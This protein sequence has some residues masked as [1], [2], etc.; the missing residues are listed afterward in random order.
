[1]TVMAESSPFFGRV[2]EVGI[3]MEA[4][5]RAS[6]GQSQTLLI[7]GEAGIGKT[8][9]LEELTTRISTETCAQLRIGAAV[10]L[11]GPTFPYGPFTAALRDLADWLP[12]DDESAHH[13]TRDCLTARCHLF[14]RVLA[15]LADLAAHT[16]FVLV[17]EDLQWAD[18]STRDLL[19]F[20]AVRLRAEHV[21]LAATIREEDLTH[22]ALRWL[23]EL[24]RRPRVTRLRL[25]RLADGDIG[26]LVTGLLPEPHHRHEAEA[27]VRAA[28][29]NPLYARELAR[30]EAHRSPASIAETVLARVSG[31]DPAVQAVVHQLSVADEGMSHDLLAATVPLPEPDLLAATRRSVS[32]RLFV[33]TG[34]VYTFAHTLTGRILYDHL[35]PG[36]RRLLHRRLADALAERG[37]ADPAVLSH[38]WYRAGRHDRAATAA[39]VAARAAMAAHAYPEA[40]S[41]YALVVELAAWLP[42]WGPGILGDAARAASL[43]GDPRRATT[44]AAQALALSATDAVTDRA[45]QLE[46]LARYHWEC[47]DL[48]ASVEAADRAADLLDG[49]PPS[50]LHAR[51]QVALARGM[52]LRGALDEA[53]AHTRRAVQY[54]RQVGARAEEAHAQATYGIIRARQGD[55]DAGLDALKESAALARKA[56]DVEEVLRSA[57][58]HMYLLCRA[59]RFAEAL[60]VARE[61]DR[62]ARAL[63]VPATYTAALNSNTAA[64]LVTTGRWDE[65]DSFIA[66]S[67]D[68]QPPANTAHHLELLRLELAVARGEHEEAARLAARLAA[69]REDP[70][71][72]GTLCAC[73]AELALA[74]DDP[75]TAAEEVA[76][77]LAA[78]D[79]CALAEEGIRL[80]ALGARIEADL[81]LHPTPARAGRQD[82]RPRTPAADYARRARA[83]VQQYGAQPAVAAFGELA[84][85]E[86]A[87][88][89]R[90]DHRAT[91]RAVADA[92]KT[93]QQPYR[94]A[95]ARL[96]EAESA[97]RAG[98]RQQA[99]RALAACEG[100]ARPLRA[101]PMLKLAE[102][103]A[104]GARLVETLDP[105]PGMAPAKAEFDL[106]RREA[107]VLG[108]LS[109]G[110]SNRQIAHTLFISD[111]TV[112]VHVSHILGKLGARNRT[113]AAAVGVRLGLAVTRPPEDAP[114]SA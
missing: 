18:G 83:I 4:F 80:L 86:H 36:E 64:V 97:I 28:D 7:T 85:A 44:Y 15:L 53:L 66:E 70:R 5:S 23:A 74:A 60:D 94:E 71:L 32:L 103:A 13:S 113:E 75:D 47:G 89:D 114:R 104:R 72:I 25:G 10:P 19:T 55:L 67:A 69:V 102:Q 2:A 58:D 91:W 81:A 14:E 101:A 96:R 16:P 87:R 29:G 43:A 26:E 37:G 57:G 92:W 38:H 20:L 61:G 65:A 88:A 56:G 21:L 31:L 33:A 109:A 22:D 11:I 95:Y 78:L 54:A 17:L 111:R 90:A 107:Q 48:G 3:A 41:L 12:P 39:L 59:G 35:L 63:G 100:L 110:E 73:L 6:R 112:A 45:Q 51:V 8:R 50:A 24:G 99:A 105:D 76:R 40:H 98:R 68:G 82:A 9:F 84:A 77:G 49:G 106:T 52:L 1:M 30:A 79:D 42:E 34:D 93:A 62:T 27:V 108:L 46:R